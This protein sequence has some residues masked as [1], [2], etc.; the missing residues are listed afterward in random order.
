LPFSPP[1][2][3]GGGAAVEARGWAAAA[4]AGVRPHR[5]QRRKFGA[6]PAYPGRPQKGRGED[7]DQRLAQASPTAGGRPPRAA[8]CG[9]KVPGSVEAGQAASTPGSTEA[10]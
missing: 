5:R 1:H 10:G 6:S 3:T 2:V 8:C 7:A 9:P 4:A